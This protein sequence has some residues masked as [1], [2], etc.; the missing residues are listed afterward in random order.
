MKSL[1]L[2]SDLKK[3]IK[4]TR[5]P[6]KKRERIINEIDVFHEKM[7]FIVVGQK[8]GFP[9]RADDLLVLQLYNKSL[10]PIL[11]DIQELLVTNYEL[12][13]IEQMLIDQQSLLTQNQEDVSDQVPEFMR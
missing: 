12:P 11:L 10:K 6:N 9:F 4:D 3:L 13:N 7:Q 1:H 8:F 2:A 5:Y